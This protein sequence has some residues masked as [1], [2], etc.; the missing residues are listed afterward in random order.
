MIAKHKNDLSTYLSGWFMCLQMGQI[1]G[2]KNTRLMLTSK[3]KPFYAIGSHTYELSLML[4]HLDSKMRILESK[5]PLELD[6]KAYSE[7][8]VFLKASYVFYRILI[9]T[10]AGVIEYFYKKSEKIN[11]PRSFNGL[12]SKH[13]NGRL[14]K[15][16]SDVIKDSI[17]WFPDF[18][19]R[20]DDLVH[21]YESFL[22]LFGKDPQNK[23]I[24][25]H[26][27]MPGKRTPTVN[28]LRDIREYLGFVL[29]EYQQLVDG[30]LDHFDSKFKGWYGIVKG[31][32]SRTETILE[33][34]SAYMIW[35]AA[36]YG[37]YQHPDLIIRE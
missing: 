6:H 25:E 27:L 8:I 33:G 28:N 2:L 29:K 9:D 14:P 24:L 7:C 18:R 11:L 3:P 5:S 19:A 30:L 1:A 31:D 34:S 37:N 13:K 36:K 12:L 15:E 17:S 26:S 10:L 4:S 16:L 32:K 22:I 23:T 21:H 20:R 35:W